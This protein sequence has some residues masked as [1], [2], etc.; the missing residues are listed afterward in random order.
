MQIGMDEEFIV[1]DKTECLSGNS[2]HV[3]EVDVSVRVK[4]KEFTGNYLSISILHAEIERFIDGL[5]KLGESGRG[6]TVLNS[7]NPKEFSL[8]IR[9]SVFSDNF[10]V[11]IVLSRYQYTGPVEW[12]TSISGGF[13]VAPDCLPA[14]FSASK[15]LLRIQ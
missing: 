14:L 1:I 15:K 9:S 6:K 3:D 11:D 13:E 10:M 5:K 7:F 8:T 12:E 2:P 4:L